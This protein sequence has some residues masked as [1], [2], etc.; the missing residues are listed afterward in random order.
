M[1]AAVLGSPVGHSLS[2]A[3]HTAAYAALGLAGEWDY[4][5]HECREEGLA[6]FL[7]GCGAEWAGLSLTMPLKREALR[8]ADEVEP[9]AREVGGANTV[10]FDR[11]GRRLAYN[12]DVHGIVAALREA[13]VERASSAAVLGG[14]ATAASAVAALRELG[15]TGDGAV[16]VWARDPKRTAGVAAA[17][18]RMQLGVATAPLERIEGRLDVDV[19]VSTLPTGAGDAYAAPVVASGAALFDVVY[20]PW[21][22]VLASAA[23]EAGRTVVDGFAMLLHQAARQ[24]ELMTGAEQAP[25]EAMRAAGLAELRRRSAGGAAAEGAE[26]GGSGALRE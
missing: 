5:L 10:V 2:P 13:G 19:V 3:L 14:G 21:P 11:R 15:A 16:T 18:E 9:L 24:V 23:Q 6:A 12:T 1:R 25:V 22:T 20:S 8:L 17:A 7:Q 26:T 4:T